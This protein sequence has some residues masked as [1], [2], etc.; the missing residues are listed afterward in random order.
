MQFDNY[1][2]LND[3]KID[4]SMIENAENSKNADCKMF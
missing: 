3:I 1:S 4:I 2:I